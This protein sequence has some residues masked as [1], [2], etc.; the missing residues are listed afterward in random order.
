[1]DD[2]PRPLPHP[3]QSEPQYAVV[4]LNDERHTFAYV[5][6]TSGKVAVRDGD[7]HLAIAPKPC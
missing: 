2:K 5:I 4:V 6:E 1:M 3:S 7:R